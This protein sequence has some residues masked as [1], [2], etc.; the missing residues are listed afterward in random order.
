[1]FGTR[2]QGQ[3]CFLIFGIVMKISETTVTL[4]VSDSSGSGLAVS[5]HHYRRIQAV[6]P[7]MVEPSVEHFSYNDPPTPLE[8]AKSFVR[9]LQRKAHNKVSKFTAKCAKEALWIRI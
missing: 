8:T 7:T 6:T 4:A 5:Q 1:M 3:S 2:R 9:R